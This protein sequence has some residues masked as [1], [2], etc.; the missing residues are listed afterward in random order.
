LPPVSSRETGLPGFDRVSV[1]RPVV[2]VIVT[3]YNQGP[4]IESALQSVFAQTYR[5]YE[6]IVVDDGSCDDTPGL[7]A[8]FANRL[9]YIRQPNQGVAGARNTGAA[10]AKGELLAFLDGDDLWDPEKLEAQVKA[11]SR[12]PT[13]GLIV[14]DGIQ[15]SDTTALRNT[16]LGPRITK[17]LQEPGEVTLRCYGELLAGNLI[18][19]ISQVMI[20]R[21]VLE[22]VGLSDIRLPVAS[23]W[24]L[25]LRIAAGHEFTFMSKRLVRWRYLS[26]SASGPQHLRRLRWATDE[27]AVLRKHL[28]LAPAVYR[29]LIRQAIATKVA[30]TAHAA[31]YVGRAVDRRTGRRYLTGL[32]FQNPFSVTTAVFLLALCLPHGVTQRIKRA[33]RCL[34]WWL[35]PRQRE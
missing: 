32:W 17:L 14:A 8:A 16:L 25:Y 35:S 11:A 19:T 23:D 34:W 22:A 29:P 2:S 24:D 31:F 30:D 5:D 9:R 4:Y 7:V 26:S 1:L 33:T 20:R 10:Q 28:H 12:H 21:A 6:L 15:F 3:T 13:S 18:S 27:M